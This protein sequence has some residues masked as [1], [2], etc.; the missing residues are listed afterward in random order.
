MA[1]HWQPAGWM[2]VANNGLTH[3][4]RAPAKVIWSSANSDHDKKMR[5]ELWAST[6]FSAAHPAITSSW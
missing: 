5:A 4:A 3:Q 2:V 1:E 6:P